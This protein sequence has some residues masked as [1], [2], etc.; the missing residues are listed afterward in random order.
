M[1]KYLLR[2]ACSY[3]LTVDLCVAAMSAVILAFLAIA[4]RLQ[5]QPVANNISETKKWNFTALAYIERLTPYRVTLRVI[6]TYL[7]D[8]SQ[9]SALDYLQNLCTIDRHEAASTNV[10]KLHDKKNIQLGSF[11]CLSLNVH[12]SSSMSNAPRKVLLHGHFVGL[13]QRSTTSALRVGYEIGLYRPLAQYLPVV[14]KQ[15]REIQRQPLPAIRHH[16]DN[17][18]MLY[19]PSSMLVY[20]QD[21]DASL[22]NFNPYFQDR[23]AAHAVRLPAYYIDK[24][25][26]TNAEYLYFCNQSNYPLPAEWREH[27]SYPLH[28]E[29]HPFRLASYHD[30][31]AYARWSS[32]RL[33][34]E[35]EWEMAARGGLSLRTNAANTNVAYNPQVFIYPIGSRFDARRCNTL[36]T[37][38]GDTIPVTEMRDESPYG[39]VGMCGNARE[40]TSSWFAPYPNHSWSAKSGIA[41]GRIF[42]VI[43]GGS[44]MEP[45]RFARSDH[46]DYGGLPSLAQD[47]S[48][49]F[50]LVVS[51]N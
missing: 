41:A 50:R 1:K 32:K 51:I 36:E 19:I 45:A 22:P 24:Y 8:D 48:A 34:S 10:L 27:G 15:R 20:G 17:K 47:R 25:E 2:L 9:T 12:H 39:I 28:K 37:G 16:K 7:R 43:R 21:S 3:N 38:R 29:K 30:A 42:K 44:F 33:P 35:L 14:T 6:D 4:P 31:Q 5:A 23:H 40:W 18:E 49:G 26:V 13:A 46:R 11:H